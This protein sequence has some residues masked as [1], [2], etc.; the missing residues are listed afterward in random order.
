MKESREENVD[1]F[2]KNSYDYISY[3]KIDDPL[4]VHWHIC[5]F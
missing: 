1:E 2:H 3:I 5:A 4:C